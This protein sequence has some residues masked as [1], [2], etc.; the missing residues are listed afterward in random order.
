[1][2]YLHEMESIEANNLVK[3]FPT[4]RLPEPED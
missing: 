4:W 3:K 2:Q 1:M